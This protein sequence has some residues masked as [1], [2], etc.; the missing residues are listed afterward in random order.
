[1]PHLMNRV[2]ALKKPEDLQQFVFGAGISLFGMS[3][4]MVWAGLAGRVMFPNLENADAVVPAYLMEAFPSW[5]AIIIIVGILSA[6]LTTADSLLHSMVSIIQSDVYE[7]TYLE[8]LKGLDEDSHNRQTTIK[9]VGWL[10][11]IGISSIAFIVGLE[12][13]D[14]LFMLTQIGIAG[15]L[16]G[17]AIPIIFGYLWGGATKRGAEAG[18]IVGSSIYVLLMF[19]IVG[20]YGG[21]QFFALFVASIGSLIAMT[22]VSPFTSN[23][24][25]EQQN[26]AF[27]VDN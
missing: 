17:T 21:N 25:R 8:Q 5:L 11:A 19:G 16:S 14:S 18:F 12:R 22:L 15:L 2:L 23:S 9:V 1:M 10:S 20:S 4:F 26:E 13:P 27:G 24:L 6:I 7:G 3:V